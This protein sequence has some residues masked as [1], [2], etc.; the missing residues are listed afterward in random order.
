MDTSPLLPPEPSE[1]SAERRSAH[2]SSHAPSHRGPRWR[3]VLAG[4]VAGGALVAAV[5]V[6]VTVHVARG[7][8]DTP[9]AATTV[10]DQAPGQ[11][12]E[13]QAPDQVPDRVTPRTDGRL[14]TSGSSSTGAD[15]SADQSAGVV[16]VDT[17]LTHGA[18]AGT[19]MVIDSGGLVLTNY[20]V[21]EGATAVTVTIATSGTSY[22][23]T[24]VGHDATADVALLKVDAT[25]LTPVTLDTDGTT[26]GER[27]T[28][29]GNG[30]G[31]GYLS[32]VTGSVLAEDQSITAS[33]GAGTSERLTGL[34]E[35]DAAAVSGFSGGPLLDDQGEVVGITTAASSRGPSTTSTAAGG[36][37][38]A[39]P[40]DS[41][42]AVVD[43]IESGDETGSVSIGPAA[44]LG[45]AVSSSGVD[46]LDVTGGGPAD[47]AGLVAGDRITGVGGASV[48]SLD[49]LRAALAMHEPGD[50][51]GL[52]WTD[53][54]GVT[55]AAAVRLGASPV[56]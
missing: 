40:I 3:A 34:L 56:S 7:G 26:A 23:A 48:S 52:R 10:P 6:P 42:L 28:A 18:G 11:F 27:V 31:Q 46:V 24:V 37:S 25:G 9:A 16:L 39:V 20:H 35:T 2:G 33:E 29:V 38:Y 36:E 49:D 13:Q 8:A 30:L 51:V 45:V 22:D 19:G 15:A 44:Y 53:A 54:A 41:A 12:G 55:H 32:A 17:V 21:V 47:G 43:R 50:R 1:P 14:D 5:A 4:A